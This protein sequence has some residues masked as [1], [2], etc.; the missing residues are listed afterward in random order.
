M[1]IGV[2]TIVGTRYVVYENTSYS[3]GQK[4][5]TTS[6]DDEEKEV[7]ASFDIN[8]NVVSAI[9]LVFHPDLIFEITFIEL[10]QLPTP[11]FCSVPIIAESF[12]KTLFHQY[13][14]P[15]AP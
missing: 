2:L 12:V 6:S 15:N 9:K 1:I 4:K 7:I 13:I 11:L 14:S 8:L 10:D 5:Q 3:Y